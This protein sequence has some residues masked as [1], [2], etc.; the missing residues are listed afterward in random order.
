M[1]AFS[2]AERVMA[3]NWIARVPLTASPSNEP[4][5]PTLPPA[6]AAGSIDPFAPARPRPPASS[7]AP[8]PFEPLGD[9]PSAAP[10]CVFTSIVRAGGKVGFGAGVPSRLPCRGIEAFAPLDTLADVD[11]VDGV[12]TV[13]GLDTF[14]DVVRVDDVVVNVGVLVDVI[15]VCLMVRVLLASAHPL[16]AYGPAH[17]TTIKAAILAL[18]RLRRSFRE[19]TII[20]TQAGGT[21]AP[22]DERKLLPGT[23]GEGKA[24]GPD[25]SQF[26]AFLWSNPSL[27]VA[28]PHLR[29]PAA[30]G[31]HE[32]VWSDALAQAARSRS[33]PAV[34]RGGRARR[35][36]DGRSFQA[37]S[38][39]PALADRGPS[40]T[41]RRSARSLDT[42]PRPSAAR[43][44][45][46]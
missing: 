3:A 17:S 10:V 7:D 25:F 14:D 12:D 29:A 13:D 11:A 31:P 4:I 36:T 21:E 6:R 26:A 2:V 22:P 18:I 33:I 5:D 24:H 30:A 41:F 23:P 38:A 46:R 9:T 1:E 35:R 43:I 15:D 34:R 45:L 44:T 42:H 16:A 28:G 39:L 19:P 20:A 32:V 27:K 37:Q 8:R 40:G